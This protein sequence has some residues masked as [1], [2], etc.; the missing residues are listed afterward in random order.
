M[1]S[2]FWRSSRR[3]ANPRKPAGEYRFG[4]SSN[5][6]SWRD[7]TVHLDRMTRG[8]VVAGAA[9]MFVAVALGAFGAHVLKTRIT[10]EM[11][12]VYQ[13]GVQYHAIHALGL[14]LLA[15]LAGRALPEQS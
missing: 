15:S 8:I 10:P 6:R 1:R 9:N 7:T 4:P 2:T 11:L 3:P 5:G 12:A 14:L 13:T